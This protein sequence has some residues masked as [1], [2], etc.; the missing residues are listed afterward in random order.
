MSGGNRRPHYL[1]PVERE[2]IAQRMSDSGISA[3]QLATAIGRTRQSIR[4][5]LNGTTQATR[6]WSA[7]VATLGGDPPGGARISVD[8]D[9]LRNIILRW[10]DMS[11][12]DKRL[13]ELIAKRLGRDGS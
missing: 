4:L 8:D 11:E 7:I 12:E 5:I 1:D 10:P 6:D 9:R 3:Q 13:T 2:W